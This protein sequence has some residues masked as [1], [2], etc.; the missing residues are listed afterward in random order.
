MEDV[1]AVVQIRPEL[2]FLDEL[3]RFSFAEVAAPVPQDTTYQV[4]VL[5]G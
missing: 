5:A 1:Q 2:P 3:L 4:Q